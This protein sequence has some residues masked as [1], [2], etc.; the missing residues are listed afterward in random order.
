MN[1]PVG[2][3]IK[4]VSRA[5]RE[6]LQPEL[7]TDYARS[8]LAGALDILSKLEQM[9]DWS[10]SLVEEVDAALCASNSALAAAAA[11]AGLAV[12]AVTTFESHADASRAL[13]DW[14]FQTPMP[15]EERKRLDA[16]LRESLRACVLAQRRRIPRAD[17]SAMT[18]SS[19]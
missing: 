11:A 9:A 3:L 19:D 10:P 5:L 16:I 15:E 8:Q 18:A 6:H 12:P 13:A 1:E 7:T 14:L 17:F 4:C 2:L